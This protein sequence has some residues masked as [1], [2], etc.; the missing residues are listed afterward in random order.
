MLIPIVNPDAVAVAESGAHHAVSGWITA[1]FGALLVV[2]IVALALEEKIHAKKSVIVGV[3]AVVCLLLAAILGI[4]P[5]DELTLDRAGSEVDLPVYIPAVDWGVIC[6]ILGSSLFVDIT[7][8]GGLFSWIAVRLTKTSGGDPL[9]LLILYSVMTV[10]FSALLNNV[11]AMIIIGSLT[12]VSLNRLGRQDQLLG[13]LLIEGLLTNVG[14]LLTLISSVPNIIIGKTA[15]ISF[16]EFFVKASPYVLVTMVVTIWLGAKLYKI[17]RLSSGDE[18][19]EAA[20]RVAGFDEND[21]VDSAFGFWLGAV[22]LTAFIA[23]IAAASVPGWFLYD[24]G[25]GYVAMAFGV[26]MLI[27]Y[28]STADRV[29]QGLDW[30]LL[31]F[32]VFLF[33]VINVM[34]HA[35]VLDAIGQA[36]KPVFSMGASTGPLVLMFTSAAVSSVTDNIP[37]AAMLAR[38]LDTV[39]DVGGVKGSP[40]W[41]SVIFG[42]NLGGNLTPIGSASTL[43]AVAIMHKHKLQMSFSRFVRAAIPFALLQLALA[44]AYMLLFLR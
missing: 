10:V 31:G 44:A 25:M 36:L 16:V 40:Y 28:K 17:H 22:M 14:G 9:K 18:R 8:R 15:G 33:I 6:I 35:L 13:F 39:P 11:T 30:D 42:A 4:L 43:V 38:I 34:E 1:V 12:A 5:F 26:V 32:F 7:A 3:S 27:R 29:Y 24:L 21:G 2:M 19:S 41:W 23:C 20:E 37:L